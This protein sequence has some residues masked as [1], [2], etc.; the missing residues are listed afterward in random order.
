M[1]GLRY[2]WAQSKNTF[3]GP[4]YCQVWTDSTARVQGENEYHENL[5]HNKLFLSTPE[6]WVPRAA[7]LDCDVLKPPLNI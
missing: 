2:F 1:A 5:K 4:V 7:A 6:R 3:V